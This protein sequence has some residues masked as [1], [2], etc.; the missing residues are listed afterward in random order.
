MRRLVQL[1]IKVP[2]G[3]TVGFAVAYAMQAAIKLRDGKSVSLSPRSIYVQAK[4][5][6]EWPGEGYEGTSVDGALKAM[7][8]SGAYLERDWPYE[9]KLVPLPNTLPMYKIQEY[10]QLKGLAQIKLALSQGKVVMAGIRVTKDFDTV[11][12]SGEVTIKSVSDE[13]GTHSVCIV[14]FDPSTE[15]IKFANMWGKSWG[16]RG[17]GT[18]HQND[19]EKIL[20][21]A[22]TLML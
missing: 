20:V 19:L 1:V 22:Y 3:S 16:N 21:S 7:K 18:I 2:E 10:S 14:G 8:K 15:K 17:F 12:K 13:L 4:K 9:S 6:D 5:Y 11:G